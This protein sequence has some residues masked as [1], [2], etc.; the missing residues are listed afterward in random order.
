MVLGPINNFCRSAAVA[1]RKSTD[2]VTKR[3]GVQIPTVL[4]GCNQ[5]KIS[6]D[7]VNILLVFMNC[8][9]ETARSKSAEGMKSS[10][11]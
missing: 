3:S 10:A 2:L 1:Q 7:C 4:S 11:R 8:A 6:T 9:Y 5:A